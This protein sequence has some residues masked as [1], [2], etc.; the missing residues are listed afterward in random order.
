MADDDF[1]LYGEDDGFGNP[2]S[3]VQVGYCFSRSQSRINTVEKEEEAEGEGIQVAQDSFDPRVGDKRPREEDES[4]AQAPIPVQSYQVKQEVPT[5]PRIPSGPT[6]GGGIPNGAMQ[7]NSAMSQG[8]VIED[9]Y[10]SLYIGDLQWV[11]RYVSSRH[12]EY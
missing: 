11:R 8:Q 6:V 3:Q 10:D 12:V 1:D 4:E 5:G 7:S 2:P 9:G